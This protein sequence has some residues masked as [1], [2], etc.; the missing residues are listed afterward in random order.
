[1]IK[2]C[3]RTAR[4]QD[5]QLR[6]PDRAEHSIWAPSSAPL[7]FFSTAPHIE[8]FGALKKG[9]EVPYRLTRWFLGYAPGVNFMTPASCTPNV[10]NVLTPM[11]GMMVS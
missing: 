7:S 3:P 9:M 11:V 6:F 5:A 1:M 2:S 8:I 10:P 4:G